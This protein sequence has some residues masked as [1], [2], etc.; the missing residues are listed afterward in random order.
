MER[1]GMADALL[2]AGIQPAEYGCVARMGAWF[3]RFNHERADFGASCP[4]LGKNG[5]SVRT[6]SLIHLHNR[7]VLPA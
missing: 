4:A 2:G 1:I 7:A 3:S 5:R 6:S